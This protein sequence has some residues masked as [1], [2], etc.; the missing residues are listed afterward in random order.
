MPQMGRQPLEESPEDF[1]NDTDLETIPEL[2]GY[3]GPNDLKGSL[4]GMPDF[5][6][7]AEVLDSSALQSAID[8]HYSSFKRTASE[9]REQSREDSISRDKKVEAAPSRTTPKVDGAKLA[10]QSSKHGEFFETDGYDGTDTRS[11]P[12]TPMQP[13]FTFD[14]G[15]P[16]LKRV[17]SEQGTGMLNRM[18]SDSSLL[19]MGVLDRAR[20]LNGSL[21][22]SSRTRHH[23]N[24]IY[25]VHS[26]RPMSR[27]R[28]DCGNT[29]ESPMPSG[30]QHVGQELTRDLRS[31][32]GS[33]I[34]NANNTLYRQDQPPG[35]GPHMEHSQYPDPSVLETQSVLSQMPYPGQQIQE[36]VNES[37]LE[38]YQNHKHR[39]LVPLQ[40]LATSH[41]PQLSH[42]YQ[43]FGMMKQESPELRNGGLV[44]SSAQ[45]ANQDKGINTLAL[46]DSTVPHAEAYKHY[47]VMMLK[48]AMMDMNHAE[49]NAGMIATW[50]KMRVD[51]NKVEQACW[52]LIVRIEFRISVRNY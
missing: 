21:L 1:W 30:V 38:P 52:A 37:I 14:E 10:P 5:K 43:G 2:L 6:P 3:F 28:E 16:A 11:N 40:Q 50:N 8:E 39:G 48:A 42:T 12:E 20:S 19:H 29:F 25:A 34:N 51:G 46:N 17:Q 27:L 32:N 36:N 33:N 24:A 23:Q 31:H 35:H 45:E 41:R 15:S 26:P 13:E 4:E 47:Y 22:N 9:K 18:Q 44:Y 7:S 49:D